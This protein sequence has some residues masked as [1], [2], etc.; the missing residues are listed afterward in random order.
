MWVDAHGDGPLDDGERLLDRTPDAK[1][2]LRD[3]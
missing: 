1:G 2:P 3:V